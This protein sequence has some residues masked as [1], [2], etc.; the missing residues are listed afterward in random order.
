[1]QNVYILGACRTPIGAFGGSLKNF[2]ASQ[3]GSIVMGEVLIRAEIAPE[4]VEYVLM[5]NVLQAGQGQNPA[6]QAQLGA[7]IPA[8]TPA[9]T[10]NKVCGSGLAAVNLAATMIIAGQ[11]DCIMAG[12]MESM[13]RAPHI[14]DFRWGKKMGNVQALDTMVHDGLT[15]AMGGYHMGITAENVAEYYHIS[16]E[17][18]DTFAAASQQKAAKARENGRFAEEIVTVSIP[19]RKGEPT[20]FCEDEFIRGDTTVEKLAKLSPAFLKDGTVTAGNSSGINDG[21]AA[22]LVVSEVFLKKYGKKALA[23]YN[24]GTSVGVD[25]EMMGIG[26]VPTVRKALKQAGLTMEEIDLVEA[27]EAF[28][29]QAV[30]VGRELSIEESK[31]NVNGGAIALGH[32]IGASGARIAVTLLYEMQKREAKYGLATLCIGGGMGEAVIFERDQCCR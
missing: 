30:A 14:L 10:L 29:A 7:K 16:R 9:M 21:A 25:P 22:M 23:K 28:A 13:S 19:Q 32:P 8:S 2:C 5:G 12:G 27:N 3:L 31:L 1:M 18:Q 17:E 15:D 20:C 11:A 24:V 26:P 4:A 6:R